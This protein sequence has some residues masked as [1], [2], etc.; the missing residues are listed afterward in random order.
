LILSELATRLGCDLRGQGDVDVVRV[1][2]LEYAG[3]GDL[4][5]VANQRYVSLLAK[6]RASAVIVSPELDTT[7]PSL[8]SKN[9]YLAYARSATLL[10]P[11]P[12]PEPG[13]HPTAQIDP[14]AVVG[15]G[16]HVGPFAVVGARSRLGA[17][18]VLHP[19]VVLYAD[20]QI[21]DDCLLHSGV[22]VR[23]GSRVG[24]RVVIQNGSVIGGDGFGFARDQSGRYEKIPQIGVVVIEDDVEIGALVAIDR[25][26]MHETRIGRGAKLDNLVQIGHSVIVGADTVLAGQVGVAGSTRIGERVILAGQVGVAGHL[27]IGDGAIVT[28]QSGIPSSV[29]PGAVVSGSPAC[30]NRTWLKAS[31]AMPRLPDLIKRVRALEREIEALRAGAREE[32]D[33]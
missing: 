33:G 22:Q 23:E 7:L 16:A 19:H 3:P 24:N 13:I 15:E 9:P 5:F 2:G 14:S 11:Q 25:S 8:V 6:T 29:E 28:A 26:S 4:S 32:D 17:R 21:G 1:S 10:H 27:T 20:V 12:R 18:S 31:A 30:D